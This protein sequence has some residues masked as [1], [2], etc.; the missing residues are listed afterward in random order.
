MTALSAGLLAGETVPM[1]LHSLSVRMAPATARQFGMDYTLEFSTYDWDPTN[2]ELALAPPEIP[3][4]HGGYLR[5]LDP[6]TFEPIFMP[7]ALDV[8]TGT[9]GNKNGIPDFFEVS[10]GVSSTVTGGIYEDP[11][12]G[13]SDLR[14]TWSRTAGAKSG[15]CRLELPNFGLVFNHSFE[16]IEFQGELTYAKSGTNL[17]GLVRLAQTLKPENTLTGAMV[18]HVVDADHVLVETNSLVNAQEAVL[19]Y[20]ALEPLQ[21]TRTNYL[22][23]TVVDDGS[24]AVGASGYYEWLLLLT[25]GRDKDA[26]TIPDLSDLSAPPPKPPTLALRLE[27]KSLLL[28]IAGEAGR[29]YQIQQ[30]TSLGALSWSSQTTVTLT[31]TPQDVVISPPTGQTSFWRVMVQ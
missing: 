31:N 17:T 14:A 16:I 25:D 26:D 29:G 9:D 23:F 18:L 1:R 13:T 7:A 27:G 21:R 10:R 11:L 28:T 22:A 5:L 8:P 4:T 20:E 15:T 24:A 6:I 3:T 12:W 2:G 19:N 30:K